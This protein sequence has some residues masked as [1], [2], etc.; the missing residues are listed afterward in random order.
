MS[1]FS[2]CVR[3]NKTKHHFIPT[4]AIAIPTINATT[5]SSSSCNSPIHNSDR[6]Y[7]S[8]EYSIPKYG[9]LEEKKQDNQLYN[10]HCKC[11][12]SFNFP[13]KPFDNPPDEQYIKD[14][15]LNYIADNHLKSI[16]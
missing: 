14:M 8:Y 7:T 5:L 13:N 1:N 11:S 6:S 16:E 4:K 9:S 10:Y 15:Y 12:E 3:N 2:D